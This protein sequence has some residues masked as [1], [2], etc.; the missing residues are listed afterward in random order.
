MSKF[1]VNVGI[2]I[3]DEFLEVGTVIEDSKLP[4]KSLK[5]L[6][7]QNIIEKY[8]ENKEKIRARNE[9]GHYIADNP[10]TPEN[11]A[12]YDKQKEEE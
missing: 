8:D 3:K 7:D 1:V 5:W 11:E 4:K 12:W 6:K 9:K 2:D 10:D